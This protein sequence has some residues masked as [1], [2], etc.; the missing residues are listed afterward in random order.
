MF[1]IGRRR[2]ERLSAYLRSQ[3]EWRALVAQEHPED[4]RHV[5]SALALEALSVYVDTLSVEDR[6]VQYLSRHL[7]SADGGLDGPLARNAVARWGWDR[8][9]G[10]HPATQAAHDEFL[11]WLCALSAHDAYDLLCELAKDY[12][13]AAPAQLARQFGL[14]KAD[15]LAALDNEYRPTSH[16]ATRYS[17]GA[18]RERVAQTPRGPRDAAPTDRGKR[19]AE[20]VRAS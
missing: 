18:R 5:R 19:R 9:S 13:R 1:S 20:R 2:R 6:R 11:N 14:T 10:K 8:A 7:C 17:P 4:P 16:F 15:V 3:S 12:S